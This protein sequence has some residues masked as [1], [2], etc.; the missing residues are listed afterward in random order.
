MDATE[1]PTD[2]VY[3]S[4]L[5]SHR[6]EAE[7]QA[8]H[9][10]NLGRG[11]GVAVGLIVFLIVL[12]EKEVTT[13]PK[14]L[15]LLPAVA[16][17]VLIVR[18]NHAARQRQRAAR[19]AGYYADRIACL[20]D[21]WAGR[22]DAGVRYLERDHPSALDLDLF[23]VGSLFELLCTA[24]TGP[25][26]DKL[27]SWLLA[28]ASSEEVRSR[29]AAAAELRPRLDLH[30]DLILL[31][32]EIPDDGGLAYLARPVVATDT[33]PRVIRGIVLASPVLALATLVAGVLFHAPIILVLAALAPQA[34]I[35]LRLRRYADGVLEPAFATR[36]TLR[37]LAA[38]LR[39][40]GDEQ[41]STD[42]LS[43]LGGALHRS[44]RPASKA[45]ASLDRLL[46]LE[47][48]A[49][50]LGC[51]PQLAL[52]VAAWQR[53][54]GTALRAWIQT[55][56]EV[57][58]LCAL[59]NRAR[60]NPHDPFPGVV[61]QGPCFDAEGLGHPFLPEK[62]CVRND[63]SLG[64]Q[65]QLLIVSGSNMSGKST[66]LRTIGINTV[67]ALAGAPVRATRLRLSPLVVGATLRVEDSLREGR[68]RF[69]A[70]ALRV[71]QLLALAAGPIPLLFLLDE[72]F[73][74]TNSRDRR[75]G[76]EAAL[77]RLLDRGAVGLVTT[78]DL[79]LTEIGHLLGPCAV[80]VHFADQVV[81][82]VMSFDYRLRYGVV[83]A[84]NG[85]ALLRALGIED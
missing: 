68:S 33:L 28:P 41:F 49:I 52:A 30:E 72:I 31:A 55:L 65:Y 14:A 20:E 46:A 54:H 67:L 50:S 18:W 36:A 16:S 37:P 8:R 81:D 64:G 23:G 44:G 13:G 12:T 32:S 51:R 60:E 38:V 25:G 83:P 58:S 59:A 71:R 47:L 70:E 11:R 3:I 21:R 6:A 24:H 79:S 82:G 48:P 78:H 76:A 9:Y 42:L 17:A 66:F 34:V 1:T 80:N 77:R 57:E 40:L 45:L 74:G 27:A 69:Y 10:L 73:Q 39:R 63:V 2:A 19:A 7:L 62:Y 29:Q 35:A 56:A 5:R 61:D 75:T 43:R 15:V 22:G 4:R 53:S 84:G 85:M 26:R